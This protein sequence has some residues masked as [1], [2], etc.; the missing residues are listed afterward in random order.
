MNTVQLKLADGA[1][2]RELWD[3]QKARAGTVITVSEDEAKILT[4]R[5]PG[6]WV[7]VK[8]GKE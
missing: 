6:D 4:A 8:K 3:G 7:I 2:S 5:D 1:P